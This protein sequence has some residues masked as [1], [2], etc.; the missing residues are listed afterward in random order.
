MKF[1]QA[2][3]GRVFVIRLE[4]GDIIHETIENLAKE[5]SIKAGALIIIGG[6]DKGS[7]LVVGPGDREARPVVPMEE[8]LGDTYEIT[9]TGTLFPNE[10]GEPEL[11]MHIACGRNANTITGCIRRGVKVWQVMEVILFEIIN[12]KGMR[13]IEKR[14]GFKLLHP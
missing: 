4:H 1:S 3:Q 11:H 9:G 13:K 7:K 2:S 10:D 8:I 12:T 5:Q 6:A 14:L